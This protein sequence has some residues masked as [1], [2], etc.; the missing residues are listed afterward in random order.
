MSFIDHP[1]YYQHSGVSE[2]DLSR[3]HYLTV[4][5]LK[6]FHVYKKPRVIRYGDLI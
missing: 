3:C 1:K 6:D 4:S 2:I 5:L